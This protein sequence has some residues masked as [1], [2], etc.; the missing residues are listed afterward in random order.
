MATST[1]AAFQGIG[2]SVLQALPVMAIVGC[3]FVV[4][5]SVIFGVT[6]CFVRNPVFKMMYYVYAHTPFGQYIHDF[7]LS[8]HATA[9]AQKRTQLLDAA[10]AVDGIQLPGAMHS[11]LTSFS[12]HFPLKTGSRRGLA[13]S[14]LPIPVMG[15]NYQY[16]VLTPASIEAVQD[17]GIV[18][19]KAG[20]ARAFNAVAV[21]VSNADLLL[22]VISALESHTDIAITLT[23][24]LTTHRHMDHCG[25]HRKLVSV[26]SSRRSGPPPHIIAPLL[27]PT[28]G[29]TRMVQDGD[30]IPLVP[31]GGGSGGAH[32]V[33]HVMSVPGHTVGHVWYALA[34][35]CLDLSTTSSDGSGAGW[36]AADCPS[37]TADAMLGGEG[38]AA[39]A[40]EAQVSA[41]CVLFSGDTLFVGGVGKFFEGTPA[42]MVRNLYDVAGAG[43][44]PSKQACVPRNTVV[45]TGHEYAQPNL[46]FVSWLDP[47]NAAVS[48]KVQW[49]SAQ[50]SAAPPRATPVTTI[51][52]E[53]CF[54]PFM[55][56]HTPGVL[57]AL[58][59]QNESVL[60]S[61]S[62]ASDC[63]VHKS[64]ALLR[65][66][67]R[68]APDSPMRADRS[69]LTA[70]MSLL[71]ALKDAE[72]HTK[73]A[74]Q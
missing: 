19:D 49:V 63:E 26:W 60:A 59:T 22:S 58:A 2:T 30:C 62:A 3:T 5:A 13:S 73:F 17:S 67:A 44:D 46:A 18:T 61:A 31:P 48:Q 74:L 69:V 28:P 9:A 25:G 68:S 52:E 11:A 27:D 32:L 21:D 36:E 7:Q 15:D 37:A 42:Q 33:A 1:A 71:R 43:D 65:R 6:M 14:V 56:C 16:L 70:A 23:H 38:G 24:I 34:P 57:T 72:V 20:A 45:C 8:S 47:S 66:A 4:A 39:G 64:A 55:R 10:E 51:A 40:A 29:V 12:V 53:C 50:R 54:N 35:A 41:P